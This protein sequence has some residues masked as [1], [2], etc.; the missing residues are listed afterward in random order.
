MGGV[1]AVVL[2]PLAIFL[3]VKFLGGQD[4]SDPSSEPRATATLLSDQIQHEPSKSPSP[5][6]TA[7]PSPSASPTASA[8][9][10]ETFNPDG[11]L[12]LADGEAHH[13]VEVTNPEK[14][15]AKFAAAWANPGGDKASWL[16]G[17]RPYIT[18]ELY[19]GFGV[20]EVDFAPTDTFISAS[21]T[22]DYEQGFVK[23]NAKYKDGGRLMD[24]VALLQP[25]G[26]WLVDK[27][28][29]GGDLEL[30]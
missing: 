7:K 28:V 4:S 5:A 22:D 8:S 27:V 26:S 21:V 30:D 15:V 6:A 1:L 18:D 13:D 24:G 29:P 2:I 3:G 19:A 14:V 9:P 17:M 12:Q 11:P 10:T 16:M 20:T 23:F 25:D